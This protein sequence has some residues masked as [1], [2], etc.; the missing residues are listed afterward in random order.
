[1]PKGGYL[2]KPQFGTPR[3]GVESAAAAWLEANVG[4]TGEGVM[5]SL[6]DLIKLEIKRSKD[7]GRPVPPHG[8][9]P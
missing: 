4:T 7:P 6:A 8:S 3:D 1:M 2:T 9:G 5:R